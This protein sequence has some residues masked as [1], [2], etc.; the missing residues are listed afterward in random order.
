MAAKKVWGRARIEL[1]NP[2]SAVGL[3]TDCAMGPG[4]VWPDLGPNRLQK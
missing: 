4:F 3:A 2:A 1:T